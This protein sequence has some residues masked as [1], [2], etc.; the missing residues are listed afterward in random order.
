MPH[1][2]TIA[3]PIGANGNYYVDKWG[4]TSPRRSRKPKL[5]SDNQPL[6]R[7]IRK[8]PHAH[9]DPNA[10]QGGGTTH[11]TAEQDNALLLGIIELG[12][13]ARSKLTM[14]QWHELAECVRAVRYRTVRQ[15]RRRWTKINPIKS[16]RKVNPNEMDCDLFLSDSFIDEYT[17]NDVDANELALQATEPP[18]E[19]Q[20]LEDTPVRRRAP[21]VRAHSDPEMNV[22]TV[23]N[24]PVRAD[25][26]ST[27]LYTFGSNVSRSLTFS[28]GRQVRPRNARPQVGVPIPRRPVPRV[29]NA[30][31]PFYVPAAPLPSQATHNQRAI[32]NFLLKRKT[33]NLNSILGDLDK[34]VFV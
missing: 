29:D 25:A 9:S 26:R 33:S 15:V 24:V 30:V 21:E 16:Q 8:R 34:I 27:T 3:Y 10:E 7:P 23:P 31:A 14:E 5:G 2:R 20:A 22:R 28:F 6:D 17:L 18:L 12:I 1:V 19:D 11:W 32:T 4:T 13:D